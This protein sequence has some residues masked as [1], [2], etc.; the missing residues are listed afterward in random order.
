MPK[1]RDGLNTADRILDIAEDLVQTRG[2]NAF[3]Y[4]DVAEVM[5]V[6]KASLHYH[7]STKAILGVELVKRY[8]TRFM[9]SLDNLDRS[10]ASALARLDAYAE[11]YAGVLDTGRMCLCGMMASD[12]CTLPGPMQ[13]AVRQFFADNKVWLIR[14]IEDAQRAGDMRAS[15]SAANM[16][17]VLVSTLE[18]AMMLSRVDGSPADFRRT[19]HSIL[20]CMTREAIAA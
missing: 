14:Q 12:I 19:A 18:G 5:N 13:E 4:A 9:A 16:A 10:Q 1:P 20:K 15:G 7:F 17:Q 11:L 6:T 3:S 2:F 8:T